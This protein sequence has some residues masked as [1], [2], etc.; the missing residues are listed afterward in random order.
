MTENRN[1]TGPKTI[2]TLHTSRLV[3]RPFELADALRVQLLAGAWEIANTTATMPHPYAD[4]VAEQWIS[5]HT[6]GFEK[7]NNMPLAVCLADGTL[8]G[9]V[10]LMNFRTNHSRGELG[11]F[12]GKDYWGQG[13]CTEAVRELIRFGFEQLGLNRIFGNHMTRNPA[14]GRVMEKVGLKHEGRLR[15]H[16]RRWDKFEDIECWGLAQVRM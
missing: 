3:L 1:D 5:G 9:T 10:S 2:P 6:E 4:G 11:Y 13:Y 12:I 14:S 7:G 8:I 16:L 15:Q